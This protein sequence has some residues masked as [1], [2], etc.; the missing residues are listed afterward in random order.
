MINGKFKNET[1]LLN[2]QCKMNLFAFAVI[3]KRAIKGGVQS[4]DV[5]KTS[6]F[7]LM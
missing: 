1:I 7:G 4:M 2:D 3:I 6:L 5:Q